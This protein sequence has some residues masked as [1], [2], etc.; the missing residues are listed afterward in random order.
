MLA[1]AIV[2]N[3]ALGIVRL[4]SRVDSLEYYMKQATKK[5]KM[6]PESGN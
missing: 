6:R 5:P 3:Y 2:R 4:S 1:A